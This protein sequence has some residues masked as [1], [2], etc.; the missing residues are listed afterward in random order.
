[1]KNNLTGICFSFIAFTLLPVS[2]RLIASPATVTVEFI[3]SFDYPD[4]GY[5]LQ[6][7]G[8]I[9]DQANYVGVLYSTATGKIQGFTGGA[10]GTFSEPF[11]APDD[12]DGI[13]TPVGIRNDNEICGCYDTLSRSHGFFLRGSTFRTY[14][15][16]ILGRTD[17]CIFGLNNGGD[18]V[19]YYQSF[20]MNHGFARIG[21][22]LVTIPISANDVVALG[23]NDLDQVVGAYSDDFGVTTHGFFRASDGTLTMP[24]DF[25][26][27]AITNPSAINDSGYI[28]GHWQKAETAPRG[29]VIQLPD[30]FVSY[31]VP[32][33]TSTTFTGINKSGLIIGSYQDAQF[34]IHGFLARLRTE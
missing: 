28:V 2:P 22:T 17:T 21:Q 27:A 8:Q 30:I 13:T 25:P 34:G 3:G 1:M 32:N 11:S 15:V 4:A 12:T 31:K 18:F 7:T 16:Q 29:F 33:S 20:D 14:D 24:I 10:N 23:I 9:N 5:Q 26:T 6:G 19:G